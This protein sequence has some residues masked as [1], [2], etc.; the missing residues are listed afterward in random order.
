MMKA[1]EIIDAINAVPNAEWQYPP[2]DES[3]V[4]FAPREAVRLDAVFCYVP[5]ARTLDKEAFNAWLSS[6]L[7]GTP[8]WVH[9]LVVPFSGENR[10]L[11]VVSFGEAVAVPHRPFV[12]FGRD[13]DREVRFA[14]D[15]PSGQQ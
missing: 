8:E 2:L 3:N 13:T 15:P 11:I 6:A 12:N 7:P 14:D 5:R 10:F 9:A 1:H 4:L